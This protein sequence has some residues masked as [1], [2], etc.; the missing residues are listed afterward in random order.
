MGSAAEGI[1]ST[2]VEFLVELFRVEKV[3]SSGT[4]ELHISMQSLT[5]PH[6]KRPSMLIDCS[7]PMHKD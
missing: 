6:R 1:H 4:L 3:V 5:H 2:R 7:Y